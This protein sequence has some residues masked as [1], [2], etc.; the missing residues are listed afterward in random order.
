MTKHPP[1]FN[2]AASTLLLHP[3][4]PFFEKFGP[5]IAK[6]TMSRCLLPESAHEPVCRTQKRYP[7]VHRLCACGAKLL[8]RLQEAMQ[9]AHERLTWEA[10]CAAIGLPVVRHHVHHR[11]RSFTRGTPG[12][13][14]H[15]FGPEIDH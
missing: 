13:R 8:D 15:T 6:A 7:L 4:H 14:N 10:L 2:T 1:T 9:C 12:R 11:S 3:A 5:V